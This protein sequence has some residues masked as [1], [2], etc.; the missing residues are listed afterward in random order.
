MNQVQHHQKT[1]AKIDA[2]LVN[3]CT[4]LIKTKITV[5]S[6]FALMDG[7]SHMYTNG[8]SYK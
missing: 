1:I 7:Q 6:D 5:L 4:T 3:Q 8:R 2:S